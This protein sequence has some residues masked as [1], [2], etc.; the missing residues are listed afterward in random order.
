MS[1][2]ATMLAIRVEY[3]QNHGCK[4]PA[5]VLGSCYDLVPSATISA[6]PSMPGS[7][8]GSYM[9]RVVAPQGDEVATTSSRYS[10]PMQGSLP[11]LHIWLMTNHSC[12]HVELG[13]LDTFRVSSSLPSKAC[14]R[15]SEKH[16]V[17]SSFA[18]KC[19]RLS[20]TCMCLPLIDASIWQMSL[21]WLERD[22]LHFGFQG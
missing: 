16:S 3:H 7:H 8:G 9:H 11:E 18:S 10:V 20:S 5:S 12:L 14:T 21:L 4:I 2:E 13:C 6:N 1:S 19:T 22:M 17:H 15:L